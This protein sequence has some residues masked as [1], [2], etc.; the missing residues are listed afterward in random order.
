MIVQII[1]LVLLFM[2][3][4]LGIDVSGLA[5]ILPTIFKAFGA[6]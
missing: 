6:E 4:F 2:S 5:S 1:W 3:R